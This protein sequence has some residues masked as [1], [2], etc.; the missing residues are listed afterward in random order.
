M[1]EGFI[2]EYGEDLR[3]ALGKRFI[4][5]CYVCLAD[6]LGD[7]NCP[8]DIDLVVIGSYLGKN[9]EVQEACSY[10][11]RMDMKEYLVFIYDAPVDPKLNQLTK[12]ANLK[13]PMERPGFSKEFGIFFKRLYGMYLANC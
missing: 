9:H 11:C 3:D 5:S 1:V 6:F 10:F 12:S 2:T 4:L 7:Q 8:E 13:P